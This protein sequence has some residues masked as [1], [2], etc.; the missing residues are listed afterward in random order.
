MEKR[1]GRS[2]ISEMEQSASVNDHRFP[3]VSV[4]QRPDMKPM[5]PE[6]YCAVPKDIYTRI[7]D[8]KVSCYTKFV[9]LHFIN[10]NIDL[11]QHVHCPQ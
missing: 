10:Y 3:W 9:D 2:S 4:I 6:L 5:T 1:L 11:L 7:I 8:G